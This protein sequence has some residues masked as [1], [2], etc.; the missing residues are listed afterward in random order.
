MEGITH[1]LKITLLRK[2]KGG[3]K[4]KRWKRWRISSE[5]WNLLEKRKRRIE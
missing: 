5:N 1:G 4:E 2:V 3:N